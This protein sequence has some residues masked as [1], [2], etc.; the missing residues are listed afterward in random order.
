MIKDSITTIL[1]DDPSYQG[2][3]IRSLLPDRFKDAK[4]T[5]TTKLEDA[6]RWY[7]LLARR[8]HYSNP[9]GLRDRIAA[10]HEM[11]NE[12]GYKAF[13]LLENAK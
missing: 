8:M 5:E 11:K 6:L 3:D 1:I 2:G 9:T 10:C 4:M 12:G 13:K 7:A